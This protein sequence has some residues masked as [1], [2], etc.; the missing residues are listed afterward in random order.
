MY[1]I[2]HDYTYI[3]GGG[4]GVGEPGRGGRLAGKGKGEEG[5]MGDWELTNL[6][7]TIFLPILFHTTAILSLLIFTRQPISLT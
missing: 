5:R 3:V 2:L 4:G 1:G 6:Q 7:M